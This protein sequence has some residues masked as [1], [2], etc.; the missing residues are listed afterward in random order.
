MLIARQ[1]TGLRHTEQTARV[2][3]DKRAQKTAKAAMAEKS[4]ILITE[5]G[6]CFI[7]GGHA[8]RVVPFF[9]RHA[10]SGG[11]FQ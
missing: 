4:R 6:E 5:M 1:R 8:V 2:F 10:A 7:R 3:S 11:R 9:D